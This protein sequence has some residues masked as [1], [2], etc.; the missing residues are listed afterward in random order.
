MPNAR[1]GPNACYRRSPPWPAYAGVFIRFVFAA[2]GPICAADV[3]P[4]HIEHFVAFYRLAAAGFPTVG[5]YHLGFALA[6]MAVIVA[7]VRLFMPRHR[8][9]D[10]EDLVAE[11]VGIGVMCRLKR[12]GAVTTA[13]PLNVQGQRARCGGRSV[14]HRASGARRCAS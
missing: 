9:A 8:L 4:Y 1:I 10:A 6:S 13:S 12:F 7:L 11:I 5:V 3:I 2:I 14:P